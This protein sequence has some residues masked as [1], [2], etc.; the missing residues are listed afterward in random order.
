[1]ATYVPGGPPLIEQVRHLLPDGWRATLLARD[2]D[3]V[4]DIEGQVRRLPAGATHLFVSVGGNDALAAASLLY[5]P[6]REVVEG[7]HRL[8]AVVDRFRTAYH[9]M[10][11]DVRSYGKPVTVCTIYDSVPAYPQGALQGLA[12]F[13]DA[14]L[15]EAVLAGVPVIDLRVLC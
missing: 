8:S 3:V 13:N 12:A 4:A 5:A 7:L 1:N 9:D 10:L 15:R 14:I 11:V 6:V 2:G